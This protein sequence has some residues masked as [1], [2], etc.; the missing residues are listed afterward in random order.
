MCAYDKGLDWIS[1][2]A[3]ESLDYLTAEAVRYSQHIII[4]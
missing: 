3:L 4:R 2:E 1:A